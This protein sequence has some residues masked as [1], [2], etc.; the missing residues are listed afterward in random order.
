MRGVCCAS[1]PHTQIPPARSLLAQQGPTG[2]WQGLLAD[3]RLPKPA[4]R[5]TAGEHRTGQDRTG[6]GRTQAGTDGSAGGRPFSLEGHSQ[7]GPPLPA[8]PLAEAGRLTTEDSCL[9]EP[10]PEEVPLVACGKRKHLLEISLN[11]SKNDNDVGAP[12]WLSQ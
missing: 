5:Q 3:R 1:S 7:A 9:R 11:S 6:A 8:S 2:A 4:T 12:G 10:D